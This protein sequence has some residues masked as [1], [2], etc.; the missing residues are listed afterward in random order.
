MQSRRV[1]LVPL[2]VIT[3]VV[4][5]FTASATYV[6]YYT[7]HLSEAALSVSR[8][9]MPLLEPLMDMRL[10]VHRIVT[11]GHS[12]A[13]LG[14]AE[15]RLAIVRDAQQHFNEAFA[16]YSQLQSALGWGAVAEIS[17]SVDRLNLMSERAVAEAEANASGEPSLLAILELREAAEA[18]TRLLMRQMTLD[19]QRSNEAR[20][21][22]DA[23]GH[24]SLRLAHALR[25]LCAAVAIL[26]AS[27]SLLA[28]RRHLRLSARY[29][30]LLEERATELEQFSSRVAHDILGPL[31]PVLLGLEMLGRKLPES[32]ESKELLGRTRRS[33]GRVQLIVDGL[34]DFARAGAKPRPG[35]QVGLRRVAEGLREDLVPA[36]MDAGVRLMIEPVPDVEVACAESAVTVVLQNLVRNAIKYIGDG[37]RREVVVRAS[38]DAG[39]VLFVVQDSGPGLPP[40]TE[41]KIFEPHV[42]VGDTRLPGMG[43][44]LATVKRIVEAHGGRV[45]VQ[46]VPGNGAS[47]WVEL[48]LA[49]CVPV[50][51]DWPRAMHCVSFE[52]H[53]L[54]PP[55]CPGRSRG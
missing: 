38:V 51:R 31:Q 20:E 40:G 5:A 34:L 36:A 41:H 48:P 54:L 19:A 33:V 55:T 35:A 12:E 23:V 15:Q 1:L 8:T 18:T 49:S 4:G 29:A 22:L 50:R 10:Q 27:L 37:P 39:A 43:L 9:T 16:R 21:V 45:G 17:Y 44:G 11:L 52:A 32:P 42:R 2:L 46:S 13:D 47:F 24:R 26:G 7:M 3:L 6:E 14:P 30:A 53:E 28:L 25:W